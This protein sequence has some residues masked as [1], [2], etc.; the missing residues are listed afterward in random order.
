MCIRDRAQ[1]AQILWRMGGSLPA[2]AC[3]FSDVTPNDWYYTAVAWCSS[4]GLMPGLD[5]GTF[6]PA[7]PLTREELTLT[8]YRFARFTGASTRGRADLSQFA[9]SA[10]ISSSAQTSM[11]WAVSNGLLSGYEDN[12]I[13]PGAG[14]SR[15][16]IS[17]ILHAYDQ[18]LAKKSY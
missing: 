14:V 5:D 17:V 12:T 4:Q 9:D 6:A 16:Q 15:A 1:I 11:A 10:E 18:R 13:R 7:A 2:S 3:S 8:L